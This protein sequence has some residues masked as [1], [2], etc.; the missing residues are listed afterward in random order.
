[1]LGTCV[2]L[3]QVYFLCAACVKGK[4][5]VSVWVFGGLGQ[6]AASA[7]V[8]GNPGCI[9]WGAIVLRYHKCRGCACPVKCQHCSHS[10]SL[11]LIFFYVKCTSTTDV[12]AR[13]LL[14]FNV[15]INSFTFKQDLSFHQ[16]TSDIKGNVPLPTF[17]IGMLGR[18]GRHDCARY[19]LT[20]WPGGEERRGM[21]SLLRMHR[22]E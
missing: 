10:C 14:S 15:L 6:Q 4:A 11:S 21:L 13:L 8:F 19:V 12:K 1:V 22:Y 5:R 9:I 2:P 17:T 20:R 3:Q 16:P 18:G 7:L